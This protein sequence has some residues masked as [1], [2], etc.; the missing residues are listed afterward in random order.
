LSEV[1]SWYEAPNIPSLNTHFCAARFARALAPELEDWKAQL[2]DIKKK[3]ES[4]KNYREIMEGEKNFQKRNSEILQWISPIDSSY[5]HDNVLASTKV[6]TEY[7]D[8]GQWLIDSNEFVT[9]RAGG[10]P[11]ILWLR[12]TGKLLHLQ[13][14][15][16]MLPIR[17]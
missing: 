14:T 13:L 9:W 12:G 6:D 4:C 10:G 11:S 8:C 2:E 16:C 15:A 1:K 7:R 17:D 3:E 5:E